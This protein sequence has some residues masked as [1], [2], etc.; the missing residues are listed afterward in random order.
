MPNAT[1]VLDEAKAKSRVTAWLTL[2]SAVLVLT[3]MVYTTW[4][5]GELT[6][7]I[8]SNEKLIK[9]QKQQIDGLNANLNRT[10]AYLLDFLGEVTSQEQVHLVDSQVNWPSVKEQIIRMPISKRKL[11]LIVGLLY[12]WK[13]IPF[14]LGGH[15][16]GV[17]LDSTSFLQLVLARAGVSFNRRQGEAPSAAMMRQLKEVDTPLPGDLVFYHGQT[18]SFGF[19]ILEPGTQGKAPVGIGTLQKV[20]PLEVL[21]LD[22]VNVAHYPMIGYFHVRYPDE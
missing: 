11:A 4:R 21:S 12:A 22:H 10:E 6:D 19:L 7:A 2:V 8:K 1:V 14:T 18:G 9:A 20:A 16:L 17:G 3:A 5:L 15:S 13:D